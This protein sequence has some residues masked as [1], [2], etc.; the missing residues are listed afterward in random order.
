M[1]SYSGKCIV[2]KNLFICEL[3]DL[4]FLFMYDNKIIYDKSQIKELLQN[5]QYVSLVAIYDFQ[6]K[7]KKKCLKLYFLI[8]FR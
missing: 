7:F 6:D 4:K 8:I 1:S 2:S 5:L 3:N